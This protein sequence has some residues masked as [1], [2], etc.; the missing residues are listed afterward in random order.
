MKFHN[1]NDLLPKP[2]S[3]VLLS[4]SSIYTY[5]AGYIFD[6]E[7]FRRKV[8]ETG[9]VVPMGSILQW[10]YDNEAEHEC[11]HLPLIR[12]WYDMIRSGVKKEEYRKI[13]PY[14]LV[15]LFDF[16]KFRT[17]FFPTYTKQSFAELFCEPGNRGWLKAA[18]ESG[19]FVPRHSKVHFTLGYPR[20]DDAERHMNMDIVGITIGEPNTGWWPKESENE[21][22]FRIRVA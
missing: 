6:G 19:N 14:Y 17:T 9:D 3:K 5:E 15:R 1:P 13:T 7:N 20:K 22:F 8:F 4:K 10:A 12:Q 11:L 16:E 18:I 2:G 21:E